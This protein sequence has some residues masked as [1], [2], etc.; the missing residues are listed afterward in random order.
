MQKK[1]E[2][3]LP[4]LDK[5]KLISEYLFTSDTKVDLLSIENDKKGDSRDGL[6]GGPIGQGKKLK[7]G[8]D[9]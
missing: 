1:L 7:A 6:S 2:K 8:K 3:Q 4:H 5:V 9:L